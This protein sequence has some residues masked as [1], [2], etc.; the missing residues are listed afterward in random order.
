MS[1]SA[2][3]W[4]IL[5]SRYGGDTRQPS[6]GDLAQAID[7]LLNEN[8]AGTT[9]AAYAEHPNAWLRYGFSE[10]PVLLL[11]A[12]RKRT[13]TFSKLSDQDAP[14]AL[15]AYTVRNMERDAMLSLWKRLAKGEIEKIVADYPACG[16]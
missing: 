16:W 9:E 10:G 6:E 7:E 14:D 13:V 11:E 1:E 4:V 8:I 3:A 15:T 5:T 12:N 2:A